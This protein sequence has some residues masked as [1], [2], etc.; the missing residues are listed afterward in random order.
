MIIHTNFPE[1]YST[2]D[3]NALREPLECYSNFLEELLCFGENR[4][5]RFG[6]CLPL[7]GHS[8]AKSS[9]TP[10]VYVVLGKGKNGEITCF[11]PDGKRTAV[12][13]NGT[14]NFVG[15]GWLEARSL[16]SCELSNG[17]AAN[18][19]P[20]VMRSGDHT[21]YTSN[22]ILKYFDR[23][24]IPASRLQ[25]HIESAELARSYNNRYSSSFFKT[26]PTWFRKGILIDLYYP[27]THLLC[28]VK[29][30]DDL[31]AKIGK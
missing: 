3:F 18:L 27:K 21:V 4:N 12:F 9:I 15:N 16:V 29:S 20:C 23:I 10:S 24:V 11:R 7:L 5:T 25:D 14:W 31:L 17:Q 1:W 19:H 26:L 6:L 13:E 28:N 2:D 22:F 30:F 8:S